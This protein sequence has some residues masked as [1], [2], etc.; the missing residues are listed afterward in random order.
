MRKA[1]SKIKVAVSQADQR[2]GPYEL[3][4]KNFFL[5]PVSL[6]AGR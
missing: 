5:F 4:S 1:L 3:P 2:F 6:S